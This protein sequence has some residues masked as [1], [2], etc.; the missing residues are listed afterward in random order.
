MSEPRQDQYN[1]HAVKL[2]LCGKKKSN[3][4]LK[5]L[6]FGVVS[7]MARK[8]QRVSSPLLS[9]NCLEHEHFLTYNLLSQ[10]KIIP[11]VYNL[12]S[13]IILGIMPFA[14][15]YTLKIKH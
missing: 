10:G 14:S 3:Y 5:S 7:Y 13:N 11:H 15:Y 2:Y 9:L 8:S 6:S 1:D 4:C 12:I